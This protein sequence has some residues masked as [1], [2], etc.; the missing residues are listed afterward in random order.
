[1]I[2]PLKH[3]RERFFLRRVDTGN[4]SIAVHKNAFFFGAFKVAS[5]DEAATDH[6]LRRLSGQSCNI[7]DVG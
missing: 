3:S 1:M 2:R 6:I 4:Q 5:H 7:R